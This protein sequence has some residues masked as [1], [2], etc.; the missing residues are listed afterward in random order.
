MLISLE[1]ERRLAAANESGA[2]SLGRVLTQLD[3]GGIGR[4]EKLLRRGSRNLPS[5]QLKKLFGKLLA[6]PSTE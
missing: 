1:D 2:T 5:N 6:N 3:G 4:C